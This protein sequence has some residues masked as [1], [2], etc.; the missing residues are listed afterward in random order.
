MYLFPCLCS[1]KYIL[2]STQMASWLEKTERKIN[3]DSFRQ[4]TGWCGITKYDPL[5]D[6]KNLA[7]KGIFLCFFL[8]IHETRHAGQTL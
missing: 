7:H 8:A 6:P 2:T 5:V 3:I 1:P 4:E